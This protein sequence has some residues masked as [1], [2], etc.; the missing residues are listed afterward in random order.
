MLQL[1]C[2][3]LNA[4]PSQLNLYFVFSLQRG[5]DELFTSCIS[6]GPYIMSSG[7]RGCAVEGWEPIEVLVVCLCCVLCCYDNLLLSAIQGGKAS[8]PSL[9]CLSVCLSQP[10]AMTVKNS[11]VTSGVLVCRHVSSTCASCPTTSTRLRSSVWDCPLARSQ[12]C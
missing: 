3:A 2:C 11:K 12:T 6:N 8:V 1:S 7:R 9:D 4:E 5:S 10:M